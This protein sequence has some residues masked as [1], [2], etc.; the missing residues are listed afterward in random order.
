MIDFGIE[1][2]TSGAGTAQDTKL[3]GGLIEDLT[4]VLRGPLIERWR[5]ESGN[6]FARETL[7]AS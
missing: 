3:P 1:R 5:R 2:M 4:F 6:S 7:R